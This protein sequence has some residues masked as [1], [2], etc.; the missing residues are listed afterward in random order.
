MKKSVALA[1][2]VASLFPWTVSATVF[3]TVRGVVHDPDHRPV[4]SAQVVVKAS[5]SDYSRKLVTDAD[6]S[7]EATA[8]AVGAYIVTITKDGFA[9]SAQQIV[10]ASGSAP[11]LRF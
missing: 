6:G 2:F 5:N 10:V 3:G 1:A 4:Q 11:E 8:V 9:P 7:F